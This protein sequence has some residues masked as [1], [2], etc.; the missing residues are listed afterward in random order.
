[1]V[2]QARADIEVA[3]QKRREVA[4]KLAAGGDLGAGLNASLCRAPESAGSG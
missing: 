2:H 3:G 1:M 4:R